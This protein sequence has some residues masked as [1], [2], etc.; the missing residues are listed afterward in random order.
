MTL[1]E[2]AIACHRANDK[3]WRDPVTKA[4]V[5]RNIGELLM[6]IVCELAEACEGDRKDVMDNHLP[7]RKMFDVE[8]ADA[9]I[10]IFDLAGAHEI[11]LDT[12]FAEKMLYN[13]TRIDHTL[14]AR[15]AEGG[16]KY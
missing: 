3:W 6:L 16:K 15:A 8:L 1:N 9:L 2:Y 13:R 12:V 5:D 7:H 4:Y 10:R 11:D 14:E